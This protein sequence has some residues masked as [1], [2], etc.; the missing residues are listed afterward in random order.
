MR[1]SQVLSSLADEPG[2]RITIRT[3]FGALSDRSFAILIVLLGLPNCLPMPPPIPSISA[4][5]L[6]LIAV[7]IAIRRPAPWLPNSLMGRSIKQADLGKA[8]R[9]ALP[10][11]NTLERWS[12]PRLHIFGA[13]TG[14]ILTGAMLI[15]M[16]LGMLTAAP[17]IGQVPFG[18]GVCLMGL[19]Q[20][21]RDGVLVAS[22]L[23][24][25]VIGAALS[26]SFLYAVI[27]AVRE[28]L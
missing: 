4:L 17:L 13:R 16:A 5:L 19:G 15:V 18:L 7:Q 12:K 23:L 14:A 10:V 24:A 9:R 6:I 1:M 8:I 3:I 28:L 20:S 11:V 25:G 2:E 26:A 21:E 27:L 22:G